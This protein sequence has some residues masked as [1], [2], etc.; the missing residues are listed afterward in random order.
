MAGMSSYLIH[1]L[2]RMINYQDDFYKSLQMVN[3]FRPEFNDYTMKYF[4][5]LPSIEARLMN[6]SPENL[7]K[8][9]EDQD[10]D[11]FTDQLDK[12]TYEIQIEYEKLS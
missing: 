6:S 3:D 1:L 12:P 11:M 5:F 2:S 10:I 7:M 9:R 8:L 4:N